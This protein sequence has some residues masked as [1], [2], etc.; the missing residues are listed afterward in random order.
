MF[1]KFYFF[2]NLVMLCQLT[3][4]VTFKHMTFMC[5]STHERFPIINI[6]VIE[7][8]VVYN[9][10]PKIS[11]TLTTIVFVFLPMVYKN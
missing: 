6:F 9:F 5:N 8:P 7:C 1:V 4:L 2:S 10:G 11:P 3:Q